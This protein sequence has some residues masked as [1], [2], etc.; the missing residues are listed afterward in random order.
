LH[1]AL[2]TALARAWRQ[3]PG[4]FVERLLARGGTRW[5]SIVQEFSGF[6]VAATG[7]TRT[8]GSACRA[9]GV[10]VRTLERHL[11]A[12]GLPSAHTVFWSLTVLRAAYILQDPLATTERLTHCLPF[13]SRSAVSTRFRRYT[14]FCPNQIRDREALKALCRLIETRLCPS[15]STPE[16]TDRPAR[17]RG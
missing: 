2:H 8:V 9:L 1:A 4:G 11:Q 15:E 14:G 12:A 5:D 16:I 13:P 6:V 17:P 10:S 3:S 7:A